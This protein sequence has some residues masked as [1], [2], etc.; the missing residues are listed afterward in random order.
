MTAVT[1]R[2]WLDRLLPYSPGRPAPT[3]DGSMASNESLLGA[4]ASVSSAVASAVE[5]IH[6]YPNPLADDLRAALGELH[7]VHPDQILVGNGSDELIY[8]LA[9][10]FLGHSGRAVCA[11]PPYRIDEISSYAVGAD[12]TRVPLKNW[13]HDLQ[14][15]AS[16]TADVAFL[17]NP[18]NP[19]GTVCLRSEIERFVNTCNARLVVV[20]E[21]YVDFA[22]APDEVSA[23]DLARQGRLAVLRTFSKAF[24]LAGA[25]VG[26]LIG[27]PDV[28]TVLRKIR[29]P[30]SVGSLAQV[31]ALAALADTG[32]RRRVRDET[33]RLRSQLVAA[34][35]GA[36]YEV[37]PSHANFVLVR[38]D[39]DAALVDHLTRHDVSVR[40]GSDLGMPGA[41]RISV[42]T[43]RGL[44]MLE[45]A[46]RAG[47][48]G[49]PP[50]IRP[51][52]G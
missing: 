31:A 21:A 35:E 51:R 42:P 29:P 46:L 16:V 32:H 40:G 3:A 41:V 44:R 9:L 7:G 38:C 28:I 45:R 10:A 27:A 30:F 37:V 18:H 26:Y 11:D 23:V 25:R 4:S 5:T 52:L 50:T 6:R 13:H 39:D 24:G 1:P 14:G 36:G 33:I 15:M 34:L 12:V 2:P 22:D 8:L 48:T 47:T 17:V 49:E 19:T 43:E 20:D